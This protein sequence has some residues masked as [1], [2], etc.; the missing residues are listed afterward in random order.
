MVDKLNWIWLVHSILQK[1]KNI[2]PKNLEGEYSKAL[3]SELSR[4]FDGV[5]VYWAPAKEKSS[6][7][8]LYHATSMHDDNAC[9]LSFCGAFDD[10]LIE[11]N[12]VYHSQFALREFSSAMESQGE[13]PAYIYWVKADQNAIRLT[14]LNQDDLHSGFSGKE[15]NFVHS[16]LLHAIIVY[17]VVWVWGQNIILTNNV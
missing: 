2:K 9:D 17:D 6:T 5:E 7:K 1:T 3:Q 10:I 15:K 8:E 14:F 11:F 13:A 16:F 12:R 4:F